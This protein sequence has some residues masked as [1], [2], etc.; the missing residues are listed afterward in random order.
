MD[1]LDCVEISKYRPQ[2][3]IHFRKSKEY[4]INKQNTSTYATFPAYVVGLDFR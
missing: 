2:K 1:I 3:S 4:M